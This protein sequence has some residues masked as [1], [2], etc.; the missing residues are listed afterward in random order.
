MY[1]HEKKYLITSLQA[2]QITERLKTV[3]QLDEHLKKRKYY[4]IRSLYFDDYNDTSLKQVINGIS[5]REKYRIRIYNYKRNDIKLEKKYKINN[6]TNK[7]S[8]KLTKKQFNDIINN[9]NLSIDNK[10]PKLLNDLYLKMRTRNL[11]PKI[12]IDYNRI[13]YIY[14]SGNVRVTI[15]YNISCNHK[16]DELF[17]KEGTLIPLMDKDTAIL[18]VKYTEFIPDFIRYSLQLNELER[19]SYSKY[20]IGRLK[21]KKAVGECL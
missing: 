6:M 7:E 18:E 9:V 19:V 1:R 11:S 16:I 2:K 13:P 21:I 17:D 5:T 14:E 3:M 8:C 12:I 10:N 15:D 20:A 4:N